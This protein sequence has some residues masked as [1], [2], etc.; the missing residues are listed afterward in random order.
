MSKTKL[1]IPRESVLTVPLHTAVLCL[2]QAASLLREDKSSAF[3][4]KPGTDNIQHISALL[5]V[6]FYSVKSLYNHKWANSSFT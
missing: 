3:L 5:F 2:T 6:L 4:L 1:L